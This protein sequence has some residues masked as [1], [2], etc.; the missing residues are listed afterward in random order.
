MQEYSSQLPQGFIDKPG[1]EDTFS[2]V[3]GNDQNGLARMYG[4]GVRASDAWGVIPSRSACRREN[5]DL[6]IWNEQLEAKVA[7]LE[8]KEPERE[9]STEYGINDSSVALR[10]CALFV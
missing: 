7:R 10:V 2:K 9:R 4:L 6:K 8:G 1:P 3:I 5:I